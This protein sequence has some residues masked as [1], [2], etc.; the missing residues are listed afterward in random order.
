VTDP[1]VRPA[2]VPDKPGVLSLLEMRHAEFGLGRF[3]PARA[4]RAIQAAIDGTAAIFA[5]VIAGDGGPEATVGLALAQWFDTSEYHLEAVWDYVHPEHR[6]TEHSRKL[7][8]FAEISADR[9]GLELIMGGPIRAGHEGRVHAYC[10]DMRPAG[11]FFLY[12]GPDAP[13]GT[14][15][16]REASAAHLI[17]AFVGASK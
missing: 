13:R 10:K 5:G 8:R 12:S 3:D 4:E 9:L 16:Q 17:Q 14:K 2:A 1:L 15:R 6:K 11:A 7:R